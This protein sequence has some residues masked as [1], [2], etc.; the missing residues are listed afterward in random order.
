MGW[1]GDGDSAACEGVVEM[2]GSEK[3]GE[4]VGGV[5]RGWSRNSYGDLYFYL[6]LLLCV[7]GV[8][9]LS[10]A[11]LFRSGDD[12]GYWMGVAGAS[13]MGMLFLYPLRKHVKFARNWGRLKIWFVIHMALG[14]AGPLLILLH[15]NFRVGSLNA[16]VA[17]YSM[18]I[19]MLSGVVGRFLFVRVNQGLAAQKYALE[20]MVSTVGSSQL[21]TYQ[22][23]ETLPDVVAHMTAFDAKVLHP[24]RNDLGSHLLRLVQVPVWRFAA[25]RACDQML[26]SE[27]FTRARR[28]GWGPGDVERRLRKC[29]KLVRRH[30]A[31]VL[32]VGMLL[33]YR[34]L[35]ST[36]HV[37]HIPFVY[38]LVVSTLIH[39]VAV[40]AY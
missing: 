22:K 11:Q 5:P 20:R 16:G 25:L 27:L 37:A 2:L 30:L 35:L 26:E 12:L 39:I 13:M 8:W 31:A 6:F 40:H 7:W 24:Q 38:L 10:E 4:A 34:R 18:L 14:I 32:H 1:Y 9:T 15:S 28:Q 17:L 3:T 36:W 19:V 23:L 29:K 33:T 21:D